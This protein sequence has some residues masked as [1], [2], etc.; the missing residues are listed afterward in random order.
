VVGLCLK[1]TVRH[2]DRLYLTVMVLFGATLIS[3]LFWTRSEVWRLAASEA[4]KK[5]A[6][7]YLWSKTFFQHALLWFGYGGVGLQLV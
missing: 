7:Q 3:D 5:H 2:F 1:R 4:A 6:T